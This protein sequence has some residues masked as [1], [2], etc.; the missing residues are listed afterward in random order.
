[1]KFNIAAMHG[2]LRIFIFTILRSLKANLF[3]SGIKTLLTGL[4]KIS[5][6]LTI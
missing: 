1:M 2:H 5:V 6:K 3:G 4:K